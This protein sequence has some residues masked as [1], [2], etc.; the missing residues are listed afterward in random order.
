[1]EG[2]EDSKDVVKHYCTAGCFEYKY[3]LILIFIGLFGIAF[4]AWYVGPGSNI[5]KNK[6]NEIRGVTKTNLQEPAFVSPDDVFGRDPDILSMSS[7][8]GIGQYFTHPDTGMA[9]Y[10]VT[11]VCEDDCLS[12]WSPYTS[13]EVV[14]IGNIFTIER[15]DTGQHQYTWKGVPLYTYNDDSLGTFSGEGVDG[16]WSIVRP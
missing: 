3:V 1:M 5:V 8:P 11:G 2:N 7:D 9:I 4:L 10:K 16:I 15:E 12:D 6:F 14:R 13:D